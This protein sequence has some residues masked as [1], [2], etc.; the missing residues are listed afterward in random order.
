MKI[1]FVGKTRWE[2]AREE[3]TSNIREHLFP[4]VHKDVVVHFPMEESEPHGIEPMD[5]LLEA[6][7]AFHLF[8]F[9]R[10]LP[11]SHI[12]S[13]QRWGSYRTVLDGTPVG[14]PIFVH[15][16]QTP[17]AEWIGNVVCL[18]LRMQ[19]SDDS[20]Y[21]LWGEFVRSTAQTLRS[22]QGADPSPVEGVGSIA[23][24]LMPSSWAEECKKWQAQF[25]N[26]EGRRADA[27]KLFHR[28]T[29]EAARFAARVREQTEQAF[30]TSEFQ[31]ELDRLRAHPLFDDAY[32]VRNGDP[33]DTDIKSPAFVVRTK[34]VVVKVKALNSDAME[35]RL[36]GR[37]E[38]SIPL[39][40]N[41]DWGDCVHFYNLDRLVANQH[42][43]HI[44]AD[45]CPCFG[46]GTSTV[47][48][49]YGEG[50]IA[51]LVKFCLHYLTRVNT[52]DQWGENIHKWPL[53]QEAHPSS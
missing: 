6:S 23:Q 13:S 50:R 15:G 27:L 5:G 30:D 34:A 8:L 26:R 21:S 18:R 52:D 31:A 10:F 49:L 46:T 35:E 11:G 16:S 25:D 37:F 28:A 29:E 40:P 17:I 39:D 43:P 42:G 45:G 1:T 47:D 4:V 20:P 12:L 41:H 38:I 48:R 24:A 53:V 22:A 51:E 2:R 9:G 3:L 44:D 14:F 7:G 36:I 32:F 19:Y 33:S